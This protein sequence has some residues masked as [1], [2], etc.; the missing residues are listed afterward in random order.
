M[1]KIKN[2][3]V[4]IEKGFSLI[5]ILVV[6]M[7]IGL[8]TAVVAI[9]V[10]PSQ[11]RARVDKATADIRIMEQALELYRLDMYSYPT[12]REGLEALI[13][14]PENHRFKDRYRQGGYIK[15]LEAD[16]WGNPYQ[17]KRPGKN[18]SF[19][20]FSF[21]ADGIIGGEVWILTLQTGTKRNERLYASRVTYSFAHFSSSYH[22]G[23]KQSQFFYKK[24]Y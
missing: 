12:Q 23:Y 21:G 7:I 3:K 18:G 6:L 16:P 1:K 17:Y 19:D 5:E 20:L 2:L 8:L 4:L 15:R 13:S 24:L 10:L 9:N 14:T 11:D 22:G